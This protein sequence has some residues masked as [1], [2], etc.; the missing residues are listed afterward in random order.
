LPFVYIENKSQVYPRGIIGAT[1]VLGGFMEYKI[2]KEDNFTLYTHKTDKFKHVDFHIRFRNKKVNAEDQA[3]FGLALKVLSQKNKHYESKKV[4]EEILDDIYRPIYSASSFIN[5][6]YNTIDNSINII[7]EKYS[8][9]GMLAESIKHGFDNFFD[10]KLD[11]GFDEEQFE[12]SKKS[13]I[14]SI[15]NRQKKPEK[16]FN[17]FINKFGIPGYI[18]VSPEEKIEIL[19]KATIDE[20]YKKYNEFINNSEMNI[21]CVGDINEEEIKRIVL[22][23]CLKEKILTLRKMFHIHKRIMN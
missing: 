9:E 16:A 20:V 5:N 14:T 1:L 21:Y 10:F 4:K 7:N 3:L 18:E 8:E 6:E 19:E 15:K 23:M 22:K 2:F 12:I 17:T 11:K 13:F